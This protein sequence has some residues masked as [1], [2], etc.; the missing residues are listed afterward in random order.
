MYE[1]EI[2][3]RLEPKEAK[4]GRRQISPQLV[5][6]M[7]CILT[8]TRTRHTAVVLYSKVKDDRIRTALKGK[9][10]A[11]SHQGRPQPSSLS[12]SYAFHRLSD[13]RSLPLC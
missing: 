5:L 8:R 6:H 7:A 11:L 2:R 9:R 1:F 10:T 3:K 4:P 13:V 12:V